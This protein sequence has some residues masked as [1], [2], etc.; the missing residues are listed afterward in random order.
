MGQIGIGIIGTGSIV[1]TY[2]RC[3]EALDQAKLIAL[4]SRSAERAKTA[5][6]EFNIPVYHDLEEFLGQAEMQLVCICNES[7]LHGEMIRAAAQAG[8]QV[9]C[10]KPLEVTPEKIDAVIATCAEYGTVLGCVL[11]NRCT[12]AYRAVEA[13]VR[14]GVLGKLLLGNAHINWYR[15]NAYY[16]NNPWRG[17]LAYD[18]G[19]AFMNQGIHTI[20][21]LLNLMGEVQSVSGT[22][23]TAVHQIEG[24]DVGAAVLNFKNGAIGTLTAGTALVPGYPERL[25]VYGEEGSILMEGGAIREWNVPGVPHPMEG[26][27]QGTASGAAD[28]TNIGHRNHLIVLQD[29]LAALT[30]NRPPMVEASEARKA[31][32]VITALYRSSKENKP[33]FL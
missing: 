24:E 2:V 4:Y 28:P 17:T 9:L 7:G 27:G 5:Q 33:I 13:V 10:E 16:A 21:L 8:K 6:E 32:E 1:Q 3:I 20:D 25:E 19:A 26:Q 12:E 29:M 31:V 18:G 15:S 11:Q 30:E 23:K 22:I 14:Q